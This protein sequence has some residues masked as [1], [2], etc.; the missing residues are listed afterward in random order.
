[1]PV[2]D[3]A[4]TGDAAVAGA[5]FC[6]IGAGMA[7]LFIARR[8]AM[9]G[10]RVV[11]VE[12]GKAG[13][14]DETHELNRIVD[15]HGFYTRAL[16]GRYRGLGGSSSR[17]GGRIIPLHE[18][19]TQ[20][21]D[22]LGLDG[23]PFGFAEL[24]AYTKEIE[25]VFGLPH[26]PYGAPALEQIHL[27]DVFNPDDPDF[28]GRLAKWISFRQCNLANVW[29]RQLNTLPGLDIWLDATVRDFTLDSARGRLVAVEAANFNG[30]SLRVEAQH[31]II[32]A[33]TIETTRLLLWL[34]AQSSNHAFAGTNALGRYFQDHLKSEVATISR[35]DQALSNRLFGYHFV[36]GTRRSL[37]LDLTAAAQEEDGSTSAFVYAAMDLSKSRL[38][39]IKTV[40]RGLQSRQTKLGDL[41]GLVGEAPLVVRFAWWRYVRRQVFM[42]ADAG[43]ALQIAIEQRPNWD[44]FISLAGERDRLGIPKAEVHWQPSDDDE[45]TFRSTAARLENYWTR[46]GLDGQCPLTWVV[47]ETSDS[48]RFVDH[49]EPYAHPSG[50]TRMGTD[51]ATSIVGPELTC[52]AIPNL[53]VASASTFLTAGSANP[54]FTILKLALRLADSLMGRK[55]MPVARLGEE[56]VQAGS[57]DIAAAIATPIAAATRTTSSSPI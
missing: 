47:G 21:R 39:R 49:A 25:D 2:R 28:S 56:L 52:H 41:A 15:V 33:G 23:W 3:L 57:T 32:A 26:G 27:D 10:H 24:E 14:D 12:S 40:A 45:K 54:T 1:M 20:P 29:G 4:T 7:G 42:P 9:A 16:N 19:D 8:L 11:V 38:E 31:F 55:A 44:N 35:A 6:I 53:S 5:E 13:F 18:H 48:R 36:D 43:L 34:D 46:T 22:Y 51:P 50:S 30:N 17:W 37:H